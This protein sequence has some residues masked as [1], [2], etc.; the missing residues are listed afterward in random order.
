VELTPEEK[1]HL[2]DLARLSIKSRFEGTPTPT[3]G[4]KSENL[5]RNCGVFVTL[6]IGQ[7]LRGCIGLIIGVKPLY[8]AVLEMAQ[9]AAFEDP[10]FPSLQAKELKRIE[11]DI[12]VLSPLTE[13]QNLEEIEV[14]KH[15]LLIRQGYRSGLL[16]PQVAVEYNW[17][18]QTFLEQTCLK[19]GL[20]REAYK[21]PATRIYIFTAEIF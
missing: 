8:K 18:R 10:R 2:R 15:G 17:D 6:K 3:L 5:K 14:G 13:L 1:K 12:S 9:A 11:I 19:A 20:D 16:L 7:E 21:D 4:I